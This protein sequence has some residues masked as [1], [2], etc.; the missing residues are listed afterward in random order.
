M[1]NYKYLIEILKVISKNLFFIIFTFNLLER[2]NIDLILRMI[3]IYS[4]V[5]IF[6]FYI[7]KH[8]RR[9]NKFVVL[10]QKMT[11]Q[12]EIHFL[13]NNFFNILFQCIHLFSL[14][15][16]N[17]MNKIIFALCETNSKIKQTVN[18]SV[19]CFFFFQF[20]IYLKANCY[21]KE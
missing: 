5:I 15:H 21:Y 4:L 20:N 7:F 19:V 18:K 2:K 16:I 1:N 8:I 17:I 11:L 13:T 3:F 10:K 9:L 6:Q 14:N 12:V